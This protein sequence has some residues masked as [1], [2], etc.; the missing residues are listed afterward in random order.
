MLKKNLVLFLTFGLGLTAFSQE[1][2]NVKVLQNFAQQHKL[3]EQ[4][5]YA[6]AVALAK[7]KG[8]PI[9]E[10]RKN[11]MVIA[12]ESIDAL[13]NPVY[14]S[15]FNNTIAAATTRANQLWS[16]GSS[17]LNLSGSSAAVTGK[18]GV[19]DGGLI[20]KNHVELVGR[21]LQKDSASAPSSPFD[22]VDHA[23]HV[24]GTMIASGVNPIAK[25]MAFG[26]K[27]LVAY[28]GLVGD[29]SSIATEASNLILS[30]H[31][32]GANA[33]WVYD[34]TNYNWYGDTTVS[35]TKSYLF[36]YYDSKAQLIDSIAYNAPN[37]LIDFSAGNSNGKR[38]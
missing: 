12:L 32:Y 13:G 20:L 21:I 5:A 15:T 10:V 2:T 25:G 6:K 4:E 17:G 27:Q 29:V 35:T 23:T 22:N 16:G 3:K 18:L 1:V 8:W 36:G 24:S 7:I 33:G 9:Y 30:N 38:C 28:Y 14:N 37:Y 31:S 11:G 26:I 19:W 34:G